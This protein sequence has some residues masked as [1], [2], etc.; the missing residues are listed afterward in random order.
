MTSTSETRFLALSQVA[1]VLGIEIEEV[2]ALIH[3]GRLRGALLG[4][5]ARWQVERASVDEYLD[6]QFEESRRMALWRESNEASFPELWGAHR[7]V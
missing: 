2:T 1:E 4:S 3:Q 5:P 7:E 6:D